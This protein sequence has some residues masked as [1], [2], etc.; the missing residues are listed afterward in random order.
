MPKA[1]SPIFRYMAVGFSLNP[2]L[3]PSLLR[4][5]DVSY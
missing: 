4:Q 5:N 2:A 3:C 1:E